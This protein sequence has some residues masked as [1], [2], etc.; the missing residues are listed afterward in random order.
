MIKTKQKNCSDV[1]VV[2]K[3][4]IS[5]TGKHPRSIKSSLFET[6]KEVWQKCKLCT[7][8]KKKQLYP[9]DTRESDSKL[10]FKIQFKFLFFQF[11]HRLSP[12]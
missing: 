10:M 1:C 4:L 3:F 6:S 2:E 7:A 11:K 5:E 12:I 8:S 9:K